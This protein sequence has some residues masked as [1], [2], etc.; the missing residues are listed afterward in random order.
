MSEVKNMENA[1]EATV[2][3]VEG[4]KKASR[5]SK[6]FEAYMGIASAVRENAPKGEDG[7][8]DITVSRL[9]RSTAKG[10]VFGDQVFYINDKSTKEALQFTLTIN[11]NLKTVKHIDLS[12]EEKNSVT[13]IGKDVEKMKS[14]VKSET[15]ATMA[16]ENV[17]WEKVPEKEAEAEEDIER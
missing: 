7:K 2:E 13:Y 9:N 6:T 10:A 3:A 4:A 5:S 15:L 12:D 1:V 16:A 11:G 14:V 17:N 8:S